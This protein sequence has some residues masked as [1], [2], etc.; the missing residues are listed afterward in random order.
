MILVGFTGTQRG[1]TGRQKLVIGEMLSDTRGVIARHGDCVGADDEFD[2]LCAQRGVQVAIHPC[3]IRSKRAYCAD[4]RS[5]DRHVHYVEKPLPPLERNQ[6]I[7]DRSE[8]L[9]AAPAGFEEELRSGTW[10]T[11]RRARKRGIPVIIVLPD[12]RTRVEE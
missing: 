12:G 7:V 2:Y 1:M 11:V 9:V 5:R 10:S 3:D 8:I 4:K 6:V